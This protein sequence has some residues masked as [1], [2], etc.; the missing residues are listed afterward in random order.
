MAVDRRHLLE[1]LQVGR[2]VPRLVEPILVVQSLF[3]QV[4]QDGHPPTVRLG[5]T[6]TVWLLV[7]HGRRK[8][9]V[10]VVEVVHCQGDL[11]EVVHRLDPARSAPSIDDGLA[12]G[13][14]LKAGQV[15]RCLRPHHVGFALDA[16]LGHKIQC[17]HH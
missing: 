12:K 10:R 16:G 5:L 3:V 11:L 7:E 13:S 6:A 2:A 8:A 4:R 9:L 17:G 1:H 14:Q 15:A